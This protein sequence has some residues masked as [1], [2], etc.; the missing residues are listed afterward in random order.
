MRHPLILAAAVLPLLAA[1]GDNRPNAPAET[2][3]A[4]TEPA[5]GVPEGA[6]SEA[7]ATETVQTPPRPAP[8][9]QGGTDDWR[10][11]ATDGDAARLTRLD[12]AWREALS[13]ARAAGFGDELRTLGALVDPNAGQAGRLQPPPG[14]YRCR[15]FKLG[16][17]GETGLGYVAYPAFRC[18]VDLTPG[19]D[20]ILS[21]MTGSQRTRGLIYPDTDRRLVF[22]GAQAWGTGETGFPL[23]SE[24]S[25][26]DQIGVVERIG[27][28]RWRLVLPYPK[29]ESK[30]DVMELTR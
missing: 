20:L 6:S 29:Q 24:Q 1:C 16:K 28:N 30:L 26:R 3:P 21:K 27:D 10:A 4:V 8:G 12:D 17:M 7:A 13:E 14:E 11:V 25:Q 19:G 9:E 5:P 18:L 2:S 15:T 22:L 23:Y